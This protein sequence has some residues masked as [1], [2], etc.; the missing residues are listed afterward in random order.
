[1]VSPVSFA[2]PRRFHPPPVTV[3]QLPPLDAILVSHDHYDHLCYASVRD[4]T[5]TQKAPF[6]TSLGVGA[7]L[8]A[9]GV[10][11]ERIVEL[12]WWE[13]HL[14]PGGR[15]QF[16]AT[17]AQH[18]SGRGVGDRNATGWSGWALQ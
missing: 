6:V 12:D 14:L 2:G 4:L 17:P 10:P 16:T 15:L 7:R 8:E 3:A 11:A 13:T 1:R 5:A 18:F 9:W